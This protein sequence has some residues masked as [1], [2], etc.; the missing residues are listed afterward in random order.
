NLLKGA[1]ILKKTFSF[2]NSVNMA[3]E[4]DELGNTTSG[5]VIGNLADVSLITDSEIEIEFDKEILN[6]ADAQDTFTIEVDG[7]PVA[8]EFLSYFKFGPYGDRNGVVNVRLEE[9]LDV[10]KPRVQR[11]AVTI[12][13]DT[14]KE[15]GETA[16]ERITVETNNVTKT[17][18]FKP[19]YEEIQLGHMSQI[20][21]WGA[22]GSGNSS[23]N[24][25]TGE[26]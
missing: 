25:F 26:I 7:T 22:T 14:Q 11:R 15:K 12:F 16:A 9:P 18:K 19:F 23:S 24:D 20:E 8:W 3:S 13:D 10:G 1:N 4:K 2:K 17:A 21:A 5:S 6:D